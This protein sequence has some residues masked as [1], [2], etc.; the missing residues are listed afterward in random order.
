MCELFVHT[1]SA[2]FALT[3]VRWFPRSFVFHHRI[4]PG[5]AMLPLICHYVFVS[6][7]AIRAESFLSLFARRHR[8]A[9][10]GPSRKDTS[11]CRRTKDVDHQSFQ[12]RA[13]RNMTSTGHLRAKG[14]RD[15][16]WDNRRVAILVRAM[17][18]F[19]ILGHPS[20]ARC[21]RRVMP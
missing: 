2:F 8:D 17:R 10:L 5:H 15:R 1:I 13:N 12:S 4:V 21:Y 9:I 16:R 6:R 7:H 14:L 20:S 11:D 18:S 19:G 3:K